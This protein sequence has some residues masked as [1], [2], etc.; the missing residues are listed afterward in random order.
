MGG[1]SLVMAQHPGLLALPIPFL[2]GGALVVQ[3]PALATPSCTL[4]MPRGL[5]KMARGTS[6][7][8]RG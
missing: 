4:A 5:K 8:L 1:G 2:L 3:F 6:V 7:I